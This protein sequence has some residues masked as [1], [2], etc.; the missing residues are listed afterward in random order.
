[1]NTN[2]QYSLMNGND[3]LDARAREEIVI[4]PFMEDNVNTG[5]Y[6]VR[7]GPFYYRQGSS[8][9]NTIIAYHEHPYLSAPY[10]MYDARHVEVA[11]VLNRAIKVH[12]Y[13]EDIAS[14]LLPRAPRE[15]IGIDPNDYII[16]IGP[17][18][19][20]LGHTLEFIGSVPQPDGAISITTQM[21]SRSSS[22]RNCTDVCGSG[23]YG[24]HGFCG[25]WT[26]EIVNHS[27][28]H[29]A[30]LVVGRRIAQISFYRT[31]PIKRDYAAEG[32]Y[33][34]GLALKELQTQWQ[35]D[36]MLPRSYDDWEV[37][38]GTPHRELIEE[39]L[40]ECKE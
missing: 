39:M 34:A 30:I 40:T 20:I 24:D 3:I 28:H 9:W 10:N 6:D 33:H 5:S 25:R 19:I 13:W 29:T 7:L 2:N 18:E 1:M 21:H 31:A 37:K 15:F 8:S 35:P 17:K 4:D 26:M 16:P 22:V 23:G 32:K 38:Q 14:L 11:W 12:D 36:M 27:Q